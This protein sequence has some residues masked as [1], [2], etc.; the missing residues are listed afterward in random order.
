[1][2][3]SGRLLAALIGGWI[4]SVHSQS[5][6]PSEP[7]NLPLTAADDPAFAV[8][9]AHSSRDLVI[10]ACAPCHVPELVVAKRRTADEWDQLIATMI[11][12][13]AAADD[14]EQSRILE[15][16]VAFFGSPPASSSARE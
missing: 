6:P 16:L 1:M 12:R 15:Y 2:A 10:R 7:G 8:F 9:P 5:E 3:R 4:G 13:G 14:N 11:D